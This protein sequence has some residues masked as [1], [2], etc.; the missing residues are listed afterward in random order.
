MRSTFQWRWLLSCLRCDRSNQSSEGVLFFILAL[1]EIENIIIPVPPQRFCNPVSVSL[2]GDAC[3]EQR[4]T[5]AHNDRGME[6]LG[7]SGES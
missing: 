7:P 1:L 4:L 2:G 3:D 5:A 6:L